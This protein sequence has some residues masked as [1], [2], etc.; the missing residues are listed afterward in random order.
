VIVGNGSKKERGPKVPPPSEIDSK[1][2]YHLQLSIQ[3]VAP[4]GREE[5]K[6][7]KFK[8]SAD[9]N[10]ET[11]KK[12]LK[13]DPRHVLLW[14]DETNGRWILVNNDEDIVHVTSNSKFQVKRDWKESRKL[15]TFKREVSE[16]FKSGI[17]GDLNAPPKQTTFSIEL[18]TDMPVTPPEGGNPFTTYLLSV[19]DDDGVR[20]CFKRYSEIYQ[21]HQQLEKTFVPKGI[22]L[23][24][25]P[26][27]Q[28]FGNMD[29][30]F[31]QQRKDGLAVYFRDIAKVPEVRDSQILKEFF[32]TSL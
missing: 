23:P 6:E 11:L 28:V 19:T 8:N 31:V 30:V 20:A 10:V 13:V 14:F 12:K 1:K 17:Y 29:P 16:K 24:V 7:I 26:P 5:S 32:D 18:I 9:I 2:N 15:I 4:D 25:M 21:L 3:V 27:K 22:Q